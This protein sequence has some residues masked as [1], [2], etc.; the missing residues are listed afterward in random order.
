MSLRTELSVDGDVWVLKLIGFVDFKTSDFMWHVKNS[1]VL[2]EELIEDGVSS[3]VVDLSETDGIDSHG[4]RLLIE[5]HK[6]YSANG[7]KI[8]LRKPNS[9]LSRLF[10]IMQF[11]R[12][13]VIQPE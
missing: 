10:R 6:T 9:H 5:A 7:V 8:T 11:D 12:L 1:H 3:L 13:F 4:L 2:L